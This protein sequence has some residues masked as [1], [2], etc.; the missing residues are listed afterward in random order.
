MN[1]RAFLFALAGSAAALTFPALG[2]PP[3]LAPVDEARKDETFLAYRNRLSG[4]VRKKDVQGLL[5]LVDPDIHYTFG[6]GSG[7][8]RTGFKKEW[9]LDGKAP[10]DSEL[11][12]TLRRVLDLGGSF[13]EDGK[14]FA[15][16]Y[17][18]SRWPEQ[19]DAFT[20]G[21]IIR[22]DAVLRPKP[23]FVG[24]PVATLKYAIVQVLDGERVQKDG[25]KWIRVAVPG[26][27]QGYVDTND[28]WSPLDYR[29][30]FESRQGTW[31]MTSFVAGD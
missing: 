4:Y 5:S 12:W 26:G 7:P 17:V 18:F 1:R 31:R 20:H 28:F 13:E 8:G 2:A 25:M 27:P 6:R 24:Q 22:A 10:G 14:A 19:F 29:A 3:V 16:P 23:T 30:R 21:A 15:A 11:W 9:K